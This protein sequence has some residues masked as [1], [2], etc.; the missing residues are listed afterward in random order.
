VIEPDGEL[1]QRAASGDVNAFTEIF[2]RYQHIVRR[3]A[4][5]MTGCPA[6]A[7]D[8]SQEVFVAILRDLARYDSSRATFTTYLYGIARNL[9]RERI[10]KEWRFS[11]LDMLAPDSERAVYVSDPSD[12]LAGLQLTAHLR[13]AMRKLPPQ[14][15][16]VVELCD[17]NGF[18]YAEAA[19]IVGISTAALRSRLHRARQLLRR[20]LARVL[21]NS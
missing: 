14:Y 4:R 15:R 9:S 21:N 17:L 12:V 1:V 2:Q 19:I 8:L 6:A 3:F 7:E 18:S 11:P 13:G 5:V 16:E 20:R 10:R